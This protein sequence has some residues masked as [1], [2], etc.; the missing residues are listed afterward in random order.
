MVE[1]RVEYSKAL[2]RTAD[3]NRT[4]LILKATHISEELARIKAGT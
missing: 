3:C 4:G 2:R 1:R